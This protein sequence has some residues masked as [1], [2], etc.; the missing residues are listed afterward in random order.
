VISLPWEFKVLNKGEKD[1]ATELRIEGDITDDKWAWLYEWFGEPHAAPN[2]FRNEL[3]KLNG[4]DITIWID[5]YGGDMFA[6][7][8]MYNAL[9]EYKGKKTIKVT[10]AMS[11]ATL[12]AMAG[13]ETLMSPGGMFMIH[14]PLFESVGGDARALT[15]YAEIL[16]EAKEA[17]VNIYSLETGL[18]KDVIREM[19]DNETWMSA[20]KAVEEGFA[21]GV[22]YTESETIKNNFSFSRAT[23]LNSAK[24]DFDKISELM[25]K[26][27]QDDEPPKE[28]ALLNS[29]V[30]RQTPIDLYTK[31]N[32]IHERRLNT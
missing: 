29:E 2:K 30:T 28:A 4:K 16:D 5:S 32:K 31:L 26:N 14:N 27:K 1:E 7:I 17:S 12:P 6:G 15:H 11:A 22:L 20:N 3:K 21:S 9:K 24:F 25:K 19:M 18:D 8:G 13:D 10:K 23:V